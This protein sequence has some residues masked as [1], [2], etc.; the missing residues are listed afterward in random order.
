MNKQTI[1]FLH[2][3]P[4]FSDY[5]KPYLF[6]LNKDFKCIFYDQ[7]RGEK[8]VVKDL[9]TELD[10]IV[11]KESKPILLGHSWG[12]VLAVEYAKNNMSKI[13]GLVLMSTGLSSAQWMQYRDEL[14]AIGLGDAPP[15]KI[16]LTPIELVEGKKL[17]DKT[18]ET[19]SE[20]TF[21]SLNKTYLEKYNLLSSLSGFSFPILNVFG[22]KDLRFSQNVTK[23]FKKY[24]SSVM[25][26]EVP[27]AGHFPFLDMTNREKI[28]NKIGEIFLKK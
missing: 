26:L 28:V 10:S 9:L 19:F 7:A 8:I 11:S 3:G 20:A 27:N 5:L 24:N 23:S 14:D 25:D 18:W 22:E 13:G 17:L 1:I 12:G 15:E 2:G 16:F 6:D 4:G 21:D